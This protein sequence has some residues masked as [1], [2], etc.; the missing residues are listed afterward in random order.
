MAYSGRARR[1]NPAKNTDEGGRLPRH[2]PQSRMGETHTALKTVSVER[3]RLVADERQF[4]LSLDMTA[5]F[6]NSMTGQ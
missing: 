2:R 3:L 5:M 1:P 4:F 6:T